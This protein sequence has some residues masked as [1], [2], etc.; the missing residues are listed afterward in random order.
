MLVGQKIARAALA[1]MIFLK[2]SRKR[3]MDAQGK[4]PYSLVHWHGKE[5]GLACEIPRRRVYKMLPMRGIAGAEASLR[6]LRMGVYT[7]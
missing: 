2:I 4:T 1:M 3:E 7:I 6:L 5:G